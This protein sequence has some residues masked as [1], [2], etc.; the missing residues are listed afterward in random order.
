MWKCPTR[1]PGVNRFSG[2]IAGASAF[3]P[4]NLVEKKQKSFAHSH[5]RFFNPEEKK[6][7]TFFPLV[8]DVACGRCLGNLQW[9]S[10]WAIRRQWAIGL[11]VGPK[12]TMGN[13]GERSCS[14]QKYRCTCVP[15]LRGFCKA[16]I[17]WQ[18]PLRRNSAYSSYAPVH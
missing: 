5:D 14:G 12:M 18:N 8:P 9:F 16:R 3:S 4:G 13:K 17:R 11:A 2:W 1:F 15:N 6:V 7:D 10:S